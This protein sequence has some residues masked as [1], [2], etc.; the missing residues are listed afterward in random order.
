MDINNR[1]A[2]V[3]ANIEFYTQ[4]IAY[5]QQRDN[6]GHHVCRKITPDLSL[7][8][9]WR[10]VG[11]CCHGFNDSWYFSYTWESCIF[12]QYI[13]TAWEKLW[14]CLWSTFKKCVS[15]KYPY[16]TVRLKL[17][18][19]CQWGQDVVD[20]G[21][22]RHNIKWWYEIRWYIWYHIMSHS[23]PYHMWCRVLSLSSRGCIQHLYILELNRIACMNYNV[24][25]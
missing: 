16:N 12:M 7:T 9:C 8:W 23:M 25:I 13:Y 11:L 14:F 21:R 18:F 20:R 1:I 6:T 10:R 22:N 4:R 3:Y 19:S 24:D 5:R 2:T 15:R 17:T